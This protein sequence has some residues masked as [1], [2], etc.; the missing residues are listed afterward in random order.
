[1][2]SRL[3]V[4]FR[5]ALLLAAL[6][7]CSSDEGPARSG[8]RE[9]GSGTGV[10]TEQ[11]KVLDRAGSAALE[12]VLVEGEVIELRF[13]RAAGVVAELQE[14]DVLIAGVTE[15]TPRGGLFG[16]DEVVESEAGV[17]VVAHRAALADAFESLRFSLSTELDA[18]A[19]APGLEEQALGSVR[20]AVGEN[21]P[22][23]IP[24]GSDDASVTLEGSLALDAKPKLEID[25]DFEKFMLDELSLSFS[26]GETFV[27]EVRGE[28]VGSFDESETLGNIHFATLFV[29]IVIPGL[30]ITVPLI[31]ST[32]ARLEAGI[33]G[34]IAGEVTAGVTQYASF[35]ST[36]GYFGGEFQATADSDSD[37][38]FDEP[39]YTAG[40]SI[41]AWAGPRLEVLIWDSVGPFIG[42]D[43]YVE[44][45]ASVEGDP[46]C[47]VGRLD[48][49]LA[50]VAG[51]Q[52]VG[53]YT[54]TLAEK[55]FPL[56]SFDSCDPEVDQDQAA[57]TWARTY[58]RSDSVGE[59][60]QAVIQ[61]S[62]GGYFLVGES[63]LYDGITGFAA[64]T[65]ALR[66]DA[67]G[68]VIWQRA[69]QRGLQGLARGAA[70]VPGGFL[71]VGET[72][73]LK[74]DSGGNLR[75]AKQYTAE[76]GLAL[77]SAAARSDGQVMLAGALALTGEALALRIDEQGEVVWGRTFAG[78]FFR[79]VRVTA[80]GGSILAG[81][82]DQPDPDFYAV[83]LDADGAVVWQRSYDN[84]FDARHGVEDAEPNVVSS[85]DDGRDAIEKPDGGF[86]LV[87][88]SYANFPIPEA[89]PVG[90][91]ASAVL[92][93]DSDGEIVAS[94]LHR[95]PDDSLY[96]SAYA[97]A[98]RPNGSTL[99]VGRRADVSGDL[100]SSEDLLLIQD[101]A[102]SVFGGAGNETVDSSGS[103]HG[104]PLQVTADGGA[105]L[106]ATSDSFSGY[107]EVWLLK[108]S[109]TGSIGSAYRSS[110][111]GSSFVTEDAT[112]VSLDLEP[113]DVA[114]EASS[115]TAEVLS[116]VTGLVESRQVP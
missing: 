94:T 105:V 107:D 106:A 113:E 64:A 65:W 51:V 19:T 108:L 84:R 47:L 46:P 38:D 77:A 80:D 12:E 55:R 102:F 6:S 97:V 31:I 98:V 10:L 25:I 96:G 49:G 29:P 70:E 82:I 33:K 110:S 59:R 21:F 50:P 23:E 103:G 26:G 112:S 28:G 37:F 8:P 17:A 91:Y 89:T 114:I 30:N 86:T 42:V 78:A 36:V 61:S 24:V 85:N 32:G 13:A 63:T 16:I 48:A 88:E 22:F 73:V 54:A 9:V 101:G 5:A 18:V 95:A 2:C 11:A 1:M 93:L 14:G 44:A 90:Y 104:M 66:L 109:R 69:F 56:A 41:R 72:G 100:L 115:F 81:R 74:V 111:A 7:G 3:A 40:A 4:L 62:D 79:R 99:V 53:D 87:G 20:Q 39:S 58:A 68:N 34:S 71:I 35:S 92:E 43:G 52:F 116:E 15:Q 67:L 57:T 83:R 60:A 76:G 27:A 45:S 75:W